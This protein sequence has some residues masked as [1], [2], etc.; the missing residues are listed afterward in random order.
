MFPH[1]TTEQ[2]FRCNF[3]EQQ[4][5]NKRQLENIHPTRGL[6]G[7]WQAQN[8]P[9]TCKKSSHALEMKSNK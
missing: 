6:T 4:T 1:F 7:N 8:I 9:R 5:S 2:N 3:E